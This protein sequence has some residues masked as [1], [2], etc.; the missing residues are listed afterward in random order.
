MTPSHQPSRSHTAAHPPHGRRAR[1]RQV[2]LGLL[3]LGALCLL[4]GW[5]YRERFQAFSSV[6]EF[7]N[8]PEASAFYVRP[9]NAL[10]QWATADTSPQVTLLAISGNLEEI[11]SNICM[12][13]SYMADVLR[14]LATE[15]PSV[16][17]IDKFYSPTGCVSDPQSTAELIS[18]ARSV[19]IPVLIGE[20][21]GTIHEKLDGACLV[22]KPQLDFGS[23]NV[24]H[25]L[26]RLESAKEHVPIRWAVL[27]TGFSRAQPKAEM[28]DSL[29]WTAVQLYDSAYANHARI[30][31]VLAADDHPYAN[32]H[33]DLPRETTTDLLCRVGTAEVRRRWS[34]DCSNPDPRVDV[35]GKIVVIGAEDPSDVWAVLDHQTWGFDLQARYIEVL[36]SGNYLRPLPVAAAFLTFALFIFVI[37]GLPTML[38]FFRPRWKHKIF[39]GH[40]YQRRRYFWLAFW[41]VAFIVITSI[42]SL[43]FRYLPPLIV[44]GDISLLAITRLLIFAA[45]STEH[46]LLHSKGRHTHTMS[47]PLQSMTEVNNPGGDG[48]T[49]GQ[50]MPSPPP[51][52]EPQQP[53]PPDPS[54]GQPDGG[55]N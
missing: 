51:P 27:P 32:L 2:L 18:A 46:P 26:T 55:A 28:G 20:S 4:A 45:E 16:I 33:I 24:Y 35:L 11:Q 7:L 47:Q 17:V 6:C 22:R 50:P 31:A 5:E 39:L 43:A 14:T 30:Q 52:P 15:H 19:S 34:V 48:G 41:T 37:E 13:R 36:L 12:G 21:T 3:Y 44:F 8:Q 49:K 29:A 9:Y 1:L 42:L 25:G 10:L 23:S 54:D 53:D 38:A 40:A